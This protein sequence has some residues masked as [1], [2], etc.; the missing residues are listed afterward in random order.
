LVWLAWLI[1]LGAFSAKLV[2]THIK[3]DLVNAWYVFQDIL[4]HLLAQINVVHVLV[5]L[6]PTLMA[7]HFVNC[8]KVED[9]Q[10][11]PLKT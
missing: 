7:A 10:I 6:S 5:V 4:M 1:L 3:M 11:R 2:H 9:L 8:V